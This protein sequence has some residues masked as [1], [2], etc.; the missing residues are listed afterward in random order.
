MD[1]ELRFLG[2][3]TALD[4]AT[5]LWSPSR[6][7]KAVLLAIVDILL[8]S[9]LELTQCVSGA[10]MQSVVSFLK[11][12]QTYWPWSPWPNI[13]NSYQRYVYLAY[14]DIVKSFPYSTQMILARQ[15]WFFK[16]PWLRSKVLVSRIRH[17]SQPHVHAYQLFAS[18]FFSEAE[19]VNS[20]KLE[21]QTNID[22]KLVLVIVH[23]PTSNTIKWHHIHSLHEY[24]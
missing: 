16:L 17:W 19:R 11:R 3:D 2:H 7:Y 22:L 14:Q 6:H 15:I 9:T 24:E 5:S 10:V 12:V 13:K 21:V 23:H 1:R 20:L 8:N 4:A 18:L